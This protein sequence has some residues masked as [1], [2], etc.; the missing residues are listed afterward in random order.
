MLPEPIQRSID[1]FARLPGVGPKTA[2]RLVF[3]NGWFVPALS[4]PLSSGAHVQPLSGLLSSEKH[5]P[6]ALRDRWAVSGD[7]G[8]T[9]LAGL[10]AAFF[11]DGAYVYLPKGAVLSSP[12]QILFFSGEESA[13]AAFF[14][15]VFVVAREGS[16]ADIMES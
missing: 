12:I 15:R 4:R 7:D 10:N 5:V 13:P 11:S 3:F 2:A 1:L 16:E 8:G 6:V 9:A 14:P